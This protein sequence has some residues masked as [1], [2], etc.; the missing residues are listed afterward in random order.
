[1]PIRGTIMDRLPDVIP[2]STIR[3]DD[4][5]EYIEG[6][7]TYGIR[8]APYD[9]LVDVTAIV[10][11][12]ERDLQIGTEVEAVDTNDDGGLDSVR[13]VDAE[14]DPGTDFTVTYDCDPVIVRYTAPF[15]DEIE[16]VAEGIDSAIDSKY[17]ED[18]EGLHLDL[19]GA[20]YGELGARRGRDDEEYREFLRGIT[21][22]FSG[23]GIVDD[24]EFIAQAVLRLEPDQV[25]VVENFEENGF[26]IEIESITEGMDFDAFEQLA[27]EASPLGV[28]MIR[29]PSVTGDTG[30]IFTDWHTVVTDEVSGLSSGGELSDGSRFAS[31]I[32]TIL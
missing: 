30:I 20:Q 13:F 21:D 12:V 3:V 1:M 19:I 22:S 8:K 15:Q 2:S 28:E 29:S 6:F 23:T 18:A 7:D 4:T 17:L 24:I 25:S 26:Y 16:D 32:P 27:Q 14:P 10:G 31:D 5:E 9:Q 11:G